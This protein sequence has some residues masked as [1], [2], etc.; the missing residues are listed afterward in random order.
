VQRYN[1]SAEAHA[2]LGKLFL[3]QTHY[4]DAVTELGRAVQLAPD[5]PG[6][7]LALAQT[8]IQWKHFSTALSFLKAIQPKFGMLPEFRYEMGLSLYGLNLFSQAIDQLQAFIT[9]RPASDAAWFVEASCFANTGQLDK[10]EACFRKAIALNDRNAE[11]YMALGQ[12]LRRD[13]EDRTHD[14]IKAFTRSL[15]LKPG[16]PMAEEQLAL[17]YEREHRLTEAEQLLQS[18]VQTSPGFQQAH[19][20]LAR[21]YYKLHKTADGN[22]E[23]A[24]ADKLQPDKSMPSPAQ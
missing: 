6:Y 12:V 20:A 11:Y 18:A 3:E 1:D 9:E 7:S 15:E 4:E 10:A 24:I 17:C 8:L 16:D 22:R 2:A 21:V 23:K 19:I 13:E 14:A 5:T